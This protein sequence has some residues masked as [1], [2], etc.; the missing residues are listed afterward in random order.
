MTSFPKPKVLAFDV[1][2]TVVDWYG[3]IAAEVDALKLGVDGGEFASALRAGYKP[4]MHRV[5]T[6]E[7]PWTKIDDL[8]RMI[9]DQVLADFKLDHMPETER[10]HLNKVWH[11]LNGW[12][13]SAPGLIELRKQFM[14]CSLSNGNLGLLANMARHASLHWDLVLSAEVFRHY[15]PDPETYLGVCDVFDIKPNE[16]ML[17]AAHKD[18]LQAAAKCGCQAAFIARPNEYGPNVEVDVSVEPAFQYHA[19][20]LLDLAKQLNR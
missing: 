7:L 18:D 14:V 12:P 9:L 2:G 16:M 6:G 4:A 5:R 15:K 8:H 10:V 19:T 17:V 20:D 11:R 13:D 1:F 3:S